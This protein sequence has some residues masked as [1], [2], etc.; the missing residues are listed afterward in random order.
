MRYSCPMKKA[1]ILLALVISFGLIVPVT[2]RAGAD[3]YAL[4]QTAEAYQ[5]VEMVNQ[6]RAGYGL[7]PYQIN[8]ALM[9]AAQ[10]HS[11]WAASA[12]YHSHAEPDGSRPRDR[13]ARAGYG[14]G[15]TFFIHENIYWGGYASLQSA[16]DWWVNSPIHFA[17]LT[18]SR[19]VEIGAGVAFNDS[20]GYLTL[21]FAVVSG[22]E[23]AVSSGG[24]GAVA[25][26]AVNPAPVVYG[27]ALVQ[28]E[29]I[30]A[31][32]PGPD[33]SIFHSVKPNEALINI[34]EAYDIELY[35][36]YGIN[37]IGDD[38]LIYPDEQLIIRLPNTPTPTPTLTP[39]ATPTAVPTFRP[40]ATPWDFERTPESTGTLIAPIRV[41]DA[42]FTDLGG[43]PTPTELEM[44]LGRR[45][46]RNL[47]TGL[48]VALGVVGLGLVG[49]GFRSI[50]LQK[51]T[52]G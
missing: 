15:A 37:G 30:L 8:S 11:N 50:R 43:K 51:T 16:M 7:Y 29:D 19:Y 38:A 44:R 4:P 12:G 34:A 13:A 27:P 10:L 32:T 41:S 5:L 18:S 40:T 6:L 22:Q 47:L 48:F 9:T 21:L 26:V 31:S 39:T 36:L 14:G 17:G 20:G 46:N 33:G 1:L 52:D 24:E 45:L 23:P 42:D 28:P 49:W 25:P 3:E 2:A 35:T